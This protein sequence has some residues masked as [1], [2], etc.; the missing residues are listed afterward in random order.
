MT[1]NEGYFEIQRIIR[2]HGAEIRVFKA[3]LKGIECY[4]SQATERASKE[5]DMEKENELRR[6]WSL[7]F[8]AVH[9]GA[10]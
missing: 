8:D 7:L 5:K 10:K 9:G 1:N 6:I 2:K 4:V 3:L